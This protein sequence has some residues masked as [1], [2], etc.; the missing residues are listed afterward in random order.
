[1]KAVL[2]NKN[3]M[4][5]MSRFD[6]ILAS[7]ALWQ[8][9][10]KKRPFVLSHGVNANC[11]MRCKFCEYWRKEPG[12]E[13][14]RDEVFKLLDDAKNSGSEFITPGQQNPFLERTCL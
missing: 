10:I 5:A 8:I 9:R 11:N 2:F 12:K 1:V 7:R 13:P 6:P 4:I 14:S 3:K